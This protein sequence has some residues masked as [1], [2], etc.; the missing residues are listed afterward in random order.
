VTETTN[1]GQKLGP[2]LLYEIVGEGGM[3]QI[4][5][6]RQPHIERDVAIKVI[7]TPYGR[8]PAFL[9]RFEQEA[10]TCARLQHPHVLPVYDA[11]LSETGQ[12]YFVMAYLRGGTLAR[13]IQAHPRGLPL[14]DVVRITAQ[15]AA[16]LDYAHQ[17]GVV[18]RDVKPGNV[19]FDLQG[20][21]YLADFGIALL[22]QAA[23]LEVGRTTG[24]RPYQA[25][26]LRDGQPASP[27]SDIYALGVMVSAMLVLPGDTPDAAP[28]WRSDLPS[29]VRVVLDQA[30][31]P[32]P[33]ARP[34]TASALAQALAHACGQP[35]LHFAPPAVHLPPS[36]GLY[37][38]AA[39][40]D[41]LPG[42]TTP[43]PDRL[44]Q[45]DEPLA[46]QHTPP[47][48]VSLAA[49]GLLTEIPTLHPVSRPA[50]AAPR[51]DSED[52]I[53]A[54]IWTG[55]TLVLVGMFILVMLSLS[56]PGP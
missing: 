20:N 30:L 45:P 31:H 33:E 17:A 52:V 1:T 19:L 49:N 13:R 53:R 6:A 38:V 14:A 56:L 21:A 55:L 29:G 7:S 23:G 24:T 22:A 46:G 32:D 42:L 28:I 40:R 18:H 2:Y 50:A 54:V 5:R 25:P 34:A 12:P 3:G 47:P 41:P 36:R 11:G 51:T 4:F 44:P 9:R 43:L 39:G 27:A 37:E 15:V 35:G 16:A 26:E 48:E 10:Q 8:H